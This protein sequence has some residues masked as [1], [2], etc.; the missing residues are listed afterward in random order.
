MPRSGTLKLITSLAAACALCL[1]TASAHAGNDFSP[2]AKAQFTDDIIVFI[3]ARPNGLGAVASAC[4][5]MRASLE[6]YG[7]QM[8]KWVISGETDL[9]NGIDGLDNGTDKAAACKAVKKAGKTFDK[10]N[11]RTE[12]DS[13]IY[14]YISFTAAIE[15]IKNDHCA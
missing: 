15:M 1:G 11:V 10:I 12:S 9:C 8:P 4:R 14:T 6:T 2:D 3:N 7:E 5:Q 13:Y